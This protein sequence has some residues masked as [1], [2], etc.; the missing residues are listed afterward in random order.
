VHALR[1]RLQIP[2]MAVLQFGFGDE[3]AHMYLPHRAVGKVIYTGTHDNDTTVGWFQSG[4]AK[5]E[6]S[7]AE[8]YLGR[9]EDGIHWAFVR[10]AQTS[11]AEFALV[12]LQDVLG[13]GSDARMNTPSEH[14][15]NWRWRLNPGQFTA[16]L[17]AKLAC[18]AEVTDRLPPAP[19][20]VADEE[21]AA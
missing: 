1:E 6:C 19:V 12:P 7:N 2:G 8:A 5:L 20:A 14:A 10:A 18:L 11:A 9:C 4:A 3:G 15:G 17:A 13:L 21:S 16:E